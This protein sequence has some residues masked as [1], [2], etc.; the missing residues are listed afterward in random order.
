MRIFKQS[1]EKAKAEQYTFL[2]KAVEIKKQYPD[3]PDY[4]LFHDSDLNTAVGAM[5]RVGNEF[6]VFI[7]I[8]AEFEVRAME[9][10]RE[11]K[12]EFGKDYIE[13]EDGTLIELST[14]KETQ[15]GG[16]Q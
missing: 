7:D 3:D 2:F 12:D 8:H 1:K 10:I 4:L 5:K 14:L 6:A 9:L 16:Y 13:E 11:V 15:E